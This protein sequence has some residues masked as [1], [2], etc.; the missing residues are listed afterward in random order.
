MMTAIVDTVTIL[1]LIGSITYGYLVSRKVRHLMLTLKELEPL[2]EA[3]STAVDKSEYSVELMRENIEQANRQPEYILEPEPQETRAAFS[4]R[5]DPY[6]QPREV[7]GLHKVRDK[8]EM[9]RA[10][11]ETSGTARV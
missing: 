7:A 2:V 6:T 8:K 1:L 5:R 10:F 11:F 3:F 4:S 9:V